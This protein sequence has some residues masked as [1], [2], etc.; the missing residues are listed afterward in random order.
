MTER[1]Y[2]TD[3]YLTEFHAHVV[4]RSPD[5]ARIYLDRSAFY[6]TSGGQPFDTGFI[7]G[8]SVI[9][10]LDEGERVAHV[11]AAPVEAEEVDCRLDWQRRFDHMQQH[12][13]QHLLSAVFAELFDI[14]TVSVH[15]G[16][17]SSTIDVDSPSLSADQIHA[18]ELRANEL[19]C[20]NRRVSVSFEEASDEIGLR[21]PSSRSGEL[22]IVSIDKLDRSACGGTHVS[23]TGEIGLVLIRKLDKVRNSTRIEFLCGLR[24]V[25]R[26]RADFDALS[27]IAHVFS[28]PIDDT[29]ALVAF[30]MG[31]LKTAEKD[32]RRLEEELGAA[33]GRELYDATPPDSQGMRRATRRL[34][35]GSLDPLRA[36][37]QA[38]CARPMAVFLGVAEEPLAILLATSRDSNLDSGKLL[39][40]AL[41]EVG[42]RGGGTPRLAQGSAPT[43]AALEQALTALSASRPD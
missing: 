23:A 31:A 22:R 9:D 17:G 37:A 2:Y 3:S 8:A 11:L 13:G 21:K 18:A 33:H 40:A 30:Q 27:Q 39:K 4:D 32:R 28:A 20:E 14:A 35:S 24:A 6:P 43:I 41:T 7:A 38:F 1:L 16:A 42:G 34:P 15:L 19:V 25:R 36:M 10:V 12:T 26:A 5:G 29:P